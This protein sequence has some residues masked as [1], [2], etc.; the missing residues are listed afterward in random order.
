MCIFSASL[1][2]LSQKIPACYP[3]FLRFIY[4]RESRVGQR[5]RKRTSMRLPT[6]PVANHRVGCQDP[7]VVTW[8]ETKCRVLNRLSPQVAFYLSPFRDMV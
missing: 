1:T 2:L 3:F 5:Q 4:L 7:E 8:A 6:E